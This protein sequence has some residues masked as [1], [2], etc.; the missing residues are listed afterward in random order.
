MVRLQRLG[1]LRHI[2]AG[3]VAVD[4]IHQ[5][6]VVSHFRRHRAEQVADPLLVLDI[7]LEV[8]HHHDPAVGPDAFLSTAE[9]PG[10]HVALHNVH[11]VLLVEGNAGNFVEAHHV[12]L[13]NQSSLPVGHIDEHA[14]DG[15]LAAAD[16]V[17]VGGDLLEKVALAGATR[18]KLDHV[19]VVLD[20]RHHSQDKNVEVP[21]SSHRIGLK[22]HAAQQ[23]IASNRRS[24]NRFRP[25]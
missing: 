4:S 17:G 2:P 14:G 7:H 16:Q 5:R 13:A 22:A 11:A 1:N 8:A 20:E 24:Q 23:E 19:V 18:A 15:R 21:G 6:R 25:L 3:E 12:V 9:L 10:L